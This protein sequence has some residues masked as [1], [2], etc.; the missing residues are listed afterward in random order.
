MPMSSSMLFI[1]MVP[2]MIGAGY[3]G[4]VVADPGC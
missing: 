3:A 4:A 2:L 1:I